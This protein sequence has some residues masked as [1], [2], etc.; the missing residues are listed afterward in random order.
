M[1]GAALDVVGAPERRGLESGEVGRL[2]EG[3]WRFSF[4]ILLR[5]DCSG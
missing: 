5:K 2:G 1:E 4:L 3:S